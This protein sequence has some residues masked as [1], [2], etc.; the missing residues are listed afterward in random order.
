[1]TTTTSARERKTTEEMVAG[2]RRQIRA[3]EVRGLDEDPWVARDMTDLADELNAAAGRTVA[4]LRAA[5]YTWADIGQSFG[6]TYQA[7]WKRW[8]SEVTS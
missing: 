2:I 7:A 5:G 1:M 4:R 3:L 6:L 8:H